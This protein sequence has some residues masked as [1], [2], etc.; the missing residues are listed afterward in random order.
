MQYSRNNGTN[1][2]DGIKEILMVFSTG[3]MPGE[4]MLRHETSYDKLQNLVF[5]GQIYGNRIKKTK[6][7]AMTRNF[8]GIE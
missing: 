6:N 5:Q 4:M 3:D 2:R 7:R 8:Q 1:G